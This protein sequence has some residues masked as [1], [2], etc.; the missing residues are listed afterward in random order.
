MATFAV[1]RRNNPEGEV[2]R[3]REQGKLVGPADYAVPV[4]AVRDMD[5]QLKAIVCGYA[6]HATVL[7][8]YQWSGDWPG[9]A[10]MALEEAFPEAVAMVWAGCGADQNPTPRRGEQLAEQYGAELADAA[11]E[12]LSG[13]MPPVDGN[14]AHRYSEIDIAFASLPT[15][16]Q[17]E[18]TAANG[19][20]AEAGRA[21]KLLAE[22][23]RQGELSAAYPYP[24][25]TWQLGRNGPA[26]VLLG[27]EVVVDY[28]L[29]LKAELGATTWIAGYTNDVMAYVPSRRV[30]A[31][32]G[33][34][35]GGA[36]VYY[37]L[38]SA[39]KLEV[40]EKIVDEVRRQV[41]EVRRGVSAI[42]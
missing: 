33:Y 39:W 29:R 16:E 42:E 35:G 12:V 15:R 9:Y 24:V 20:G 31:E 1:N 17:L 25:Q 28:S 11:G 26:F 6:C 18:S 27:G 30:L 8:G 2:P 10:Q 5:D 4:L 21:R 40:E 7:S 13:V 38:P 23:D 32:G 3:L 37:G 22:W 41:G 36:M 34:E 14:L 19:Q